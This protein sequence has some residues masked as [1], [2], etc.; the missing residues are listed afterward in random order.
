M[1]TSTVSGWRGEEGVRWDRSVN[2]Q[3][4]AALGVLLGPDWTWAH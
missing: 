1:E 2:T 4:P 3:L